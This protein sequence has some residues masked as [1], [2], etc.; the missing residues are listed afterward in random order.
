LFSTCSSG[1]RITFKI[2]LNIA[3]TYCPLLVLLKGNKKATLLKMAGLTCTDDSNMF[4][5]TFSF[6]YFKVGAGLHYWK[7]YPRPHI[8]CLNEALDD[9]LLVV[10]RVHAAGGGAAARSW[11]GR[12]C[13]AGEWSAQQGASAG[14]AHCRQEGRRQSCDAAATERPQRWHH[15][16]GTT[17]RLST[18]AQLSTN[19]S[20]ETVTNQLYNSMNLHSLLRTIVVRSIV[21]DCYCRQ[22]QGMNVS[23]I[24]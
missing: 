14:A 5:F 16:Q 23:A 13:S 9:W 24:V 18:N 1:T 8:T 10:G 15:L 7:Q 4:F 21:A 2:S 17:Y 12:R 22:V 20:A 11:Q 3:L 19:S 6:G